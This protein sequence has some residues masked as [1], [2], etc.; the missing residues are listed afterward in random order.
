MNTKT[1]R[2]TLSKNNGSKGGKTSTRQAIMDA[3]VAVFTNMDFH[4]ATMRDIGKKAGI[5][6]AAIYRHFNDK[7]HVL[8]T[9]AIEQTR[10][11]V[12]ELRE[13][14]GGLK[15]SLNKIRKM[16][17][18]YLQFYQTN[19]H[20]AW[21]IYVSITGKSWHNNQEGVDFARDMAS[22]LFDIL[23]EG[24]ENR[25]IRQ[26]TDNY[27]AMHLYFGGLRNLAVARLMTPDIDK[28]TEFTDSLAETFFRCVQ[29]DNTNKVSNPLYQ[30]VL[31]DS[32]NTPGILPA[33]QNPAITRTT[34]DIINQ[35]N[36]V[37]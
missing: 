2:T 34:S 1:N 37:R 18:W 22:V 32:K 23:K 21:I 6:Q 5:S 31:V 14:L 28:L 4:E 3:A 10:K 17:W 25:E 16:T 20:I 33:P 29:A 12:E 36:P 24:K 8:Q 13:H 11:I 7:E 30:Y 27:I 15:G 35:V 9:I 26:D 19:P